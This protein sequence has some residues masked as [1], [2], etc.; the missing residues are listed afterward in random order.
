MTRSS[1]PLVLAAHGS[2]DPG[3]AAVIT[4][5]ASIVAELRPQLDVRVGYLEHGPPAL[6]D[7]ATLGSIV[8]PVLLTNGYHVHIDIPTKAA[9]TTVTPPLGPDRRLAF[10]LAKRLRASGWRGGPVVLAAAGSADDQALEDGHLAAT[11]LS[12][13]LGVAVTAAF[14]GSGQPRLP[15]RAATAL[16]TYLIAPGKFADLVA[17][18]GAAHVAAPLGAD[19]LLA[20]IIVD[21]YD[22]ALDATRAQAPLRRTTGTD[23]APNRTSG[24]SHVS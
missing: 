2:S 12:D 10:V 15:D 16:A 17:R 13:E 7:V 18:S 6:A 21:R 5:L 3:F 1:T 8:V 9:G 23:E 11:Y 19:P 22:V 4:S 24:A 14:I 20:E